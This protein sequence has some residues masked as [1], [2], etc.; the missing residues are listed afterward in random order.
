MIPF[1]QIDPVAFELFGIAFRWYGIAYAAAFFLALEYAKL[2]CKKTERSI[3]LEQLDSIFIYIVLGVIL[4]G[5][6]GYVLFY[7]LPFYLE[8]PSYILQTWKGGMSYH[9]GLI[10]VL[11]AILF[12]CKKHNISFRAMGDVIAA[13]VPIGLFFGR[14]AN[15]INGELYGRVTSA[16]FPLAMVF[17]HAGPE[18]RHPSQL[19]Q[20]ALEGLALFII[21][22]ILSFKTKRQG[23]VG[24]AFLTGYGVFR[25]MVEFVRT[26]DDLAHLKG[27]IYAYVTQGQLLS[28]PM[29]LIGLYF[30]LTAKQAS[31]SVQK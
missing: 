23:L 30:M 28:V 31:E 17:P 19:Y 16:D 21:L 10:G 13:T 15:F 6:L 14:L 2:L 12:F 22:A 7:N 27:G 4:G 29:V 1:P 5:R 11:T 3:S 8:N 24:G 18:P 9:G 26:P 20:A 25:F